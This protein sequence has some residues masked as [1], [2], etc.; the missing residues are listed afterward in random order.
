MSEIGIAIGGG[1]AFSL[2]VTF[3]SLTITLA[4]IGAKTIYRSINK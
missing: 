4:I 1:E 2:P 3:V